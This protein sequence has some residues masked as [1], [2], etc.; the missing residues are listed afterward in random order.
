MTTVTIGTKQWVVSV[1]STP[2]EVSQGLSGLASMGAGTGM[3]FDLGVNRRQIQINMAWMMFT[4]DIV[5]INSSSGV[6]GV[7]HDVQPGDTD[8]GFEGAAGARFFLEVN[9]G[10]AEGV[11]DGDNVVV[12]GTTNGGIDI[13]GMLELMVV[14]MVMIM[15]MKMM[16]RMMTGVLEE[17]KPKKVKMLGY[18]EPPA[19]YEPLHRS[20]P[21][22]PNH[23][24]EIEPTGEYTW[25]V[26]DRA[27]GEIHTPTEI[28]DTRYAAE[29]AMI[30]SVRE[31]GRGRPH[32]QKPY[33][34]EIIS[35]PSGEVTKVIKEGHIGPTGKIEAATEYGPYYQHSIHGPERDHLVKLYGTWA[36][37]RAESVCPEDDVACVEREA[38]RLLGAHRKVYPGVPEYL[39]ITD[40]G[41]TIFTSG[42]IVSRDAFVAENKRVQDLGLTPAMGR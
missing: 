16:T 12:Q 21:G 17:P 25:R 2:A 26:I 7:L 15:M 18:G 38:S 36:V 19:G 6:V 33:E 29:Q 40:T 8:V 10:E 28:Y 9:A 13:S 22:N 20:N 42:S 37:G 35:T 1:A 24:E 5:F 11:S 32:W 34:F 14:M 3:L 30:E 4:L 41:D 39:V 27:V 31:L 23:V